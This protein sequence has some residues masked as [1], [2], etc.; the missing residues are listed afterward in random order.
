MAIVR[1]I[2]NKSNLVSHQFFYTNK[3]GLNT[4]EGATKNKASV[5]KNDGMKREV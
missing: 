1:A 3:N 4:K 2:I 5:L